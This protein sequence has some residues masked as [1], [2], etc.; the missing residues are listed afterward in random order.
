VLP[1]V[2]SVEPAGFEETLRHETVHSVLTPP[3]PLNRL[4]VGLYG[5]S[6]LYRYAEEALAE[7]YA[8]RSL[9]SGLRFP[10]VEGYVSIPR[11]AFEGGAV[12]AG[13]YGAYEWA[14]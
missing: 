10:I 12:G 5:K 14:R 4:T 2:G 1:F 11:L 6:G 13:G 8:T 9:L 7:G 3:A